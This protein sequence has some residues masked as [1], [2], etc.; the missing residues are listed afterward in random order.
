MASLYHAYQNLIPQSER[1]E[2]RGREGP[3]GLGE[4]MERAGERGQEMGS[5]RESLTHKT[6]VRKRGENR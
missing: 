6:T 1:S 3:R 5:Q 2:K 4:G